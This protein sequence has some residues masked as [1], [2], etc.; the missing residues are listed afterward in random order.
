MLQR[1]VGGI[2]LVLVTGL[3]VLVWACSQPTDKQ[4]YEPDIVYRSVGER[5]L[6]LD[7][8]AP[9]GEGPFPAVVCLH[10]GGWVGGDR[11]QMTRT[12]AVLS[13]RGYVA[14]TP[15]Y[16]LAPKHRYPDALADCKAAVAWLRENAAKYK[17]DPKRIGIMGLS[18]GGHLAV[19]TALEGGEVQAVV[20]FSVPCDLSD[21]K[22]HTA[23][24]LKRN[25]VPL[26]G[27][28]PKTHAE[29]YKKASPMHHASVKSMPAT[30][31]VVGSEDRNVPPGQSE[32]FARKINRAGGAA[33]LLV[34]QGEGHTWSGLNLLKSID[35]ML[36]FL[37]DTLQK[38]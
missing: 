28:E 34:L 26:L 29:A 32:E 37:D 12:L 5:D 24:T 22:L 1:F 36:S 18:A 6:L 20:G 8:A 14:I 35:E 27:G 33:R 38:P 13:K 19:M 15:D 7:L 4:L 17:V 30:F 25:L 16:R 3:G 11:K 2:A 10:G 23:E 31:L 9:A 21:E